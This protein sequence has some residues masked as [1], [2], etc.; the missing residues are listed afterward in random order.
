M[1]AKEFEKFQKDKFEQSG[2]F[3]EKTIAENILKIDRTSAEVG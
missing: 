2:K 1:K 3:S